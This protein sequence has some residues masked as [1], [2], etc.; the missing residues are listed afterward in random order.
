MMT[1]HALYLQTIAYWIGLL[2]HKTVPLPQYPTPQQRDILKRLTKKVKDI[3]GLNSDARTQVYSLLFRFSTQHPFEL[4][5]PA[6][7][8]VQ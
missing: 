6:K 3:A 2:D 7:R 5:P 8:G 4:A 1:F